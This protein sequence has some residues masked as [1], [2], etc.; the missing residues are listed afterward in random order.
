[1]RRWRCAR[2]RTR[3]K[4]ARARD[5]GRCVRSRNPPRALPPL[6]RTA[7]PSPLSMRR[8]DLELQVVDAMGDELAPLGEPLLERVDLV[9]RGHQEPSDLASSAVRRSWRSVAAN[10]SSPTCALTQKTRAPATT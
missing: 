7:T 4:T 6:Q 8:R 9:L 1:M 2:E 3:W 5:D 10:A